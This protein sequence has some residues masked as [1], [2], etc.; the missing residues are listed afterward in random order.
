[1]AYYE[2]DAAGRQKL[3]ADA[4][5]HTNQFVFDGVGR[6]VKTIFADNTFVTNIFNLLGQQIG[7]IDQA[8]ILV[9]NVFD[10]AGQLTG[11]V[12]PSVPDPEAGGAASN[13]AWTYLYDQYSQQY[14]MQ[15]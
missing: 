10:V 13:P 11:V 3:V 14:A 12:M 6:N 2:Y 15:D 7:K 9:S 8:T 1:M 4:S 5:S